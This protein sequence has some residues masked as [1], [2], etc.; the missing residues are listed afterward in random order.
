MWELIKGHWIW[1]VGAVGIG[2]IAYMV[3]HKSSSTSQQDLL[4]APSGGSG[5]SAATGTTQVTG[6]DP[7]INPGS[8]IGGLSPVGPISLPNTSVT[9]SSPITVTTPVNT[10]GLATPNLITPINP[11]GATNSSNPITNSTPPFT[12]SS[13]P[14]TQSGQIALS[15]GGRLIP[16][17][18]STGQD[19]GTFAVV[20]GGGQ[21]GLG[22]GSV[23]AS[24]A[25]VGIAPQ[26]G[27]N[28]KIAAQNAKAGFGA[29][30]PSMYG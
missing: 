4:V 1:I 16:A 19:T 25:S 28:Q 13:A 14:I 10:G 8:A 27:M 6:P 26:T 15:G 3:L 12:T 20:G 18:T 5:P 9:P 21:T 30:N 24:S 29:G 7:G 23:K 2:G 11:S 17:T 22:M